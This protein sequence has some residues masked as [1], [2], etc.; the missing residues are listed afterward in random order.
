MGK[1]KTLP[2]DPAK[3]L[4]SGE[5]A[6][7]YL[8]AVLE[9]ACGR[10]LIESAVGDVAR[11]GIVDTAQGKAI[12]LVVWNAMVNSMEAATLGKLVRASPDPR[13]FAL[14]VLCFTDKLERPASAGLRAVLLKYAEVGASE[15][16]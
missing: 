10:D 9:E 11:A 4:E 3:Y 6:A 13:A 15:Q 12:Q 2:W 5:D 7:D 1:T 8:N 16:G 14:E